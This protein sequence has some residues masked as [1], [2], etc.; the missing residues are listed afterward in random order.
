[1]IDQLVGFQVPAENAREEEK[2]QCCHVSARDGSVPFIKVSTR[3]TG[4]LGMGL[5]HG[6]KKPED[7]VHLWAYVAAHQLFVAKQ[8][9]KIERT[10]AV[11][12]FVDHEVPVDT[13]IPPIATFNFQLGHG[14]GVVQLSK[15]LD[16]PCRVGNVVPSAPGEQEVGCLVQKDAG[17]GIFRMRYAQL[18]GDFEGSKAG[19]ADI[20]RGY[21]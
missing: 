16:G 12:T 6:S 7:A 18:T 1:M 9:V 10:K 19:S 8:P 5:A 21:P 14:S 4:G 11:Q 20:A 13:Q 17:M 3:R 2:A 15:I